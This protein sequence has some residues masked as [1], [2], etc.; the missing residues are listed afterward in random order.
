M[1]IHKHTHT[2]QE[3][4][5]VICMRLIFLQFCSVYIYLHVIYTVHTYTHT[6]DHNV[7]L[8]WNVIFFFSFYYLLLALC[9]GIFFFLIFSS[10]T[11]KDS[12]D[13]RILENIPKLLLHYTHIWDVF[14]HIYTYTS[15]SAT[16][17]RYIIII[18]VCMFTRD[19][20]RL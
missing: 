15:Y 19:R 2:Q 18:I 8:Y 17:Y 6:F 10:H 4:G 12:H 3:Y 11:E 14:T 20:F 9:C 13:I 16:H 5:I 7:Y 1:Y